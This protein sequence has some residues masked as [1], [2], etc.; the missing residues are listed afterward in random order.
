MITPAVLISA[1]GV[2]ILSTSNRVS[3][4]VERVRSLAIT[5]KRLQDNRE[6]R[7]TADVTPA[8]R[9]HLAAQLA[10]VSERALLL[11]SAMTALY[12]AVGLLVAT[13]I[14]VGLVALLQWNYGWLPVVLGFAAACAFLYGSWLL[15]REARLALRSTLEELSF[16]QGAVLERAA[17]VADAHPVSSGSRRRN[18][19]LFYVTA[20]ARRPDRNL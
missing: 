18:G 1:S 10:Q 8:K 14:L 20:G 2:L 3:R 4:T 7:S 15:V 11:R 16:A 19:G 13:S 6:A 5:V 17:P 9:Q 12:T